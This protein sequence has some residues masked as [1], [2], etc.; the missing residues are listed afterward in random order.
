MTI[1][2]LAILAAVAAIA[3]ASAASAQSLRDLPVPAEFPPASF[4]GN[5]Y[6]DSKGCVFIRAGVGANTNWI[7]RLTGSRQQMCGFE[8]SLAR[9]APAPQPQAAPQ[10]R[11]ATAPAPRTQPAPQPQARAA[12]PAPQPR[13]AAPAPQARTAA[14]P[15]P[16]AQQQPPRVVAAAPAPRQQAAPQ[17]TARTTA[18]APVRATAPAPQVVRVETTTVP[19]RPTGS[20]RVLTPPDPGRTACAGA[21]GVSAGYMV[22]HN[23]SPVRCGPQTAPYVT[24]AS[25]SSPRG[26]VAS[27]APRPGTRATPASVPPQTRIAPRHVYQEQ[28]TSLA[29]IA[30]PP[31]MK[32]VWEDDRLNPQRAH[33][34]FEGR[35]Q[36]L[37]MWTNTVPQRLIDRRTGADVIHNF[38]GLQPPFTSF[39]QQRAAGVRV[40]TRGV[41]VPD[42]VTVRRSGT[43]EPRATAV[44]R[45]AQS[46]DPQAVAQAP[47]APRATISTRSTPDATRPRYVQA[48]VYADPAQARAAAG[49]IA[50]A[51][52][53]ARQGTLTRD[54]R[55]LTLVL[56]GPFA[57]QAEAQRGAARLS[58]MG[59]A[60][61]RLR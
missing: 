2:R 4:A 55:D 47:A 27:A 31:G 36:M 57:S 28:V 5:Q 21:S 34:T 60:N 50:G 40:A 51:G 61:L 33:Q 48:G 23:G 35:E 38:P 58:G 56:A 59:F 11:T 10:A 15:P 37:V 52:L 20:A 39:E 7:P 1:S 54:G 24:Y 16:R 29:G 30:V 26:S 46:P 32:P 8:P 19:P 3:G 6:V 9:A 44:A 53:P 25:G 13:T 45:A 49:R 12:A 14:A 22:Q 17:Q 18:P 42:P 41:Y 43:G